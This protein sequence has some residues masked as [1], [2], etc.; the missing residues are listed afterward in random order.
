M[1]FAVVTPYTSGYLS[2][3]NTTNVRLQDACPTNKADHV[4]A[5]KNV[6]VI[7]WALNALSTSGPANP[8]YRPACS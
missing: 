2:G 4:G 5:P 1:R 7:R 6:V 3:P 8:A